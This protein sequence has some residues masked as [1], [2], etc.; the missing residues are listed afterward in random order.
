MKLTCDLCG[1]ELQMNAGGQDATCL[2]CGLTYSIER[3]KEKMAASGETAPQT[4]AAEAETIYNCTDYKVVAP[5]SGRMLRIQSKRSFIL[6]TAEA[7]LDGEACAVLKN[8]GSTA[9]VP[10]A[11][12]E[13]EISFRI[14]TAAGTDALGPVRFC[15]GDRDWNGVFYLHRGAFRVDQK[16]DMWEDA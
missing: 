4:P 1:G 9:E 12:G 7:Y 10:V 15:V 16:F 11:Q 5:E 6:F 3:L 8:T 13:H 14:A 2:N